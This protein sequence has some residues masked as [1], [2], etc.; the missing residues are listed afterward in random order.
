MKREAAQHNILNVSFEM[1]KILRALL[2]W[3]E[4]NPSHP[5]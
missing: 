2:D 4:R 1:G 5:D 3:R